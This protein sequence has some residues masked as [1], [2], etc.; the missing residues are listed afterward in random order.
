M[1]RGSTTD[2]MQVRIA[3]GLIFVVGMWIFLGGFWYADP[4]RVATP[5]NN[6]LLGLV[7][8]VIAGLRVL[9]PERMVGLSRMNVLL[10]L[11]LSA[12]PFVLGYSNGGGPAWADIALGLI[13]A[14]LALLGEPVRP[15]ARATHWKVTVSTATH[16]RATVL[17]GA[18]L[19]WAARG[20]M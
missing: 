18:A 5:W 8:A 13:I 14:A 3:S 10:G 2:L 11:W 1:E 6:A 12:S 20:E 9:W 7:I 19:L 17:P 16:S 15:R 4:I